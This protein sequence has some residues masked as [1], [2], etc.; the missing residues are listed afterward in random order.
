MKTLTASHCEKLNKVES[1]NE[2]AI[3]IET[4]AFNIDMLEIEIQVQA[5]LMGNAVK[6]APFFDTF[7]Y[8]KP[9][10]VSMG[11]N[12]RVDLKSSLRF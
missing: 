9:L 2:C 5:D 6:R 4:L 12:F 11:Q 3:E 7:I 1:N 10:S 8:E